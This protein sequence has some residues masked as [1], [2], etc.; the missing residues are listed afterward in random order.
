M[1]QPNVLERVWYLVENGV[2]VIPL[3]P[4][5]KFPSMRGW[6]NFGIGSRQELEGYVNSNYGFGIKP[7]GDWVYIDL[8]S[9]HEGGSDGVSTFF[10]VVPKSTMQP[11]VY[12]KKRGSRNLHLFYRNNLNTQERRTGNEQLAP[13]LEF[14]AR[15]SQ[16]R[17]EPAYYFCNLDYNRPFLDQL[18]PIPEQ[19][20]PAL[21][22]I[23][24]PERYLNSKQRANN[25]SKYLAKCEPFQPGGRSSGYRNLVFVMVIKW[26]MP[27]D[28]VKPA[29]DEWDKHN[30]DF[31]GSEPAE[32]EHATR[33]PLTK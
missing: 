21:T 22:P 19:L 15:D 4:G 1:E 18:A 26:G 10:E 24:K 3:A 5:H 12:A 8:D 32:Y 23:K 6:Q 28:E 14:S 17:I 16:V 31:Q 11:T 27:Y 25:I 2:Q 9:D 13:G 29:L 30:G 20:E 33:D 7:N